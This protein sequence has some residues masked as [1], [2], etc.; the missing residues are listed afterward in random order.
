MASLSVGDRSQAYGYCSL[1]VGERLSASGSCS[2]AFGSYVHAY[3]DYSLAAGKWARADNKHSVAIGNAT[4]ADAEDAFVIGKGLI[5]APDTH[6]ELYNP[7]PDSLMVGFNTTTEPALFVDEVGVGVG[8]IGPVR[9]L[10]VGDVMRLEPLDA[11]PANPDKGDLY[12][13]NTINK[14]RCYDG[15]AWQDCF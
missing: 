14:L 12:F 4:W 7:Y 9:S 5:F 8:I 15:T 10:H 1:A 3:G 13:D 2:V 6:M 11:E